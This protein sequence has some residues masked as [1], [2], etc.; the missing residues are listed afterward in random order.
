MKTSQAI[1][2]LANVQR[3]CIQILRKVFAFLFKNGSSIFIIQ[4]PAA[5]EAYNHSLEQLDEK[6]SKYIDGNP[7]RIDGRPRASGIFDTVKTNIFSVEESL[8]ISA[9]LLRFEQPLHTESRFPQ[10]LRTR[11]SLTLLYA[12][13]SFLLFFIY[14][15]FNRKKQLLTNGLQASPGVLSEISHNDSRVVML[16]FSR[17]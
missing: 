17:M 16:F 6:V 11:V 8:L 13:T 1:I 12:S 3:Y 14:R 5:A 15:L 2:T 7:I 4:S 10:N 9:R